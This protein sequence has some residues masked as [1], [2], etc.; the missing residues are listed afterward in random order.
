ME[1]ALGMPVDL[2]PLAEQAGPSVLAI[3]VMDLEFESSK[4]WL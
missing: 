1:L 2:A 3:R 4:I